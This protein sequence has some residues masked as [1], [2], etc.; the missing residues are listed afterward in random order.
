[1]SVEISNQQSYLMIKIDGDCAANTTMT[2]FSTEFSLLMEESQLKYAIA[3]CNDCST[4]SPLVT[5]ELA[6]IYKML[7]SKNGN[8]RIVGANK[9]IC[10]FIKDQGLDRILITKTSLRGALVDFG[11]VKEREFDANFIN[12]FLEATQRVFKV[13]CFMDLNPA[14]PYVKKNTDPLLLGDVSGIISINSETF[15]GTLAI[16]ISEP[17]FIHIISNMLGDKVTQIEEKNVDLVGELAN[18]ILGQ[19][20]LKLLSLGYSIQSALPS[21]V[22]GKDHKIKHFGGGMCIVLPF[23]SPAGTIYSEIMT[24]TQKVS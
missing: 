22:W 20:K 15:N 21:C 14:K 23:E 24:T 16:S 19:A 18:M 12:P 1:M 11:L 9:Q 6:V 10:E 2:S 5:K 17:I 7:K 3:I 4:F 8:L 13:Q